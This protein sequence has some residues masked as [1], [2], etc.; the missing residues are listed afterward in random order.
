MTIEVD[1]TGPGVRP[2]DAETI[3][4]PFHTTKPLGAGLG[5][6]VSREIVQGHGGTLTC[7]SKSG[8]GCFVVTV[9]LASTPALAEGAE[10]AR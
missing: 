9:P 1:D 7:R 3:F 10:V 5:L 2:E 8:G 4:R 6:A